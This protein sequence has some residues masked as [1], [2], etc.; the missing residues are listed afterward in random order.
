M[1]DVL[2]LEKKTPEI[3]LRIKSLVQQIFT[4]DKEIEAEEDN[5]DDGS[6]RGQEEEE[7]DLNKKHIKSTNRRISSLFD[8]S[9]LIGLTD[10]SKC[11]ITI[12]FSLKILL[13]IIYI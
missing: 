8:F 7:I 1:F 2:I 10:L 4:I 12:F 6:N 3:I 13:V 9:K 11:K 5:E